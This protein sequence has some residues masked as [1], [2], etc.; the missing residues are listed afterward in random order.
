MMPVEDAVRWLAKS[1]P[2]TRDAWAAALANEVGLIHPDVVRAILDRGATPE[3]YRRLHDGDL[4]SA[5][6]RAQAHPKSNRAQRRA[7]AKL[8]RAG[9]TPAR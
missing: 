9:I 5:I 1:T 6:N 7:R 8:K 4:R 2:H 3:Q